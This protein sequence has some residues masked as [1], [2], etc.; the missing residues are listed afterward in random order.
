MELFQCLCSVTG[1]VILD[2]TDQGPNRDSDG[3]VLTKQCNEG[4]HTISFQCPDGKTCSPSQYTIEIRDTDPIAP[5]EV[6]FIC[7]K[8][9]AKV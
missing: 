1:R 8:K 9:R 4:L 7:R 5:L 2:G 3:S 6:A